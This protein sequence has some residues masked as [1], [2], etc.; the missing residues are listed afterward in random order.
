MKV[1]TALLIGDLEEEIYMNQSEGFIVKEQEKKVYKL[2]NSLYGL[3]QSP[4][5]WH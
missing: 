4:K 2:V 5:Q 1:N 3:K